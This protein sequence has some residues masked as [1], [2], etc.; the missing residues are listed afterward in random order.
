M[1]RRRHSHR[2]DDTRGFFRK[3]FC[4]SPIGQIFERDAWAKRLLQPRLEQGGH[5]AELERKHQNNV[6]SPS[7]LA[8]GVSMLIGNFSIFVLLLALGKRGV[9]PGEI[10]ARDLMAS[11]PRS[12]LVGVRQ[13][14]AEV[15]VPQCGCAFPVTIRLESAAFISWLPRSTRTLR[16]LLR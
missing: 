4:C 1:D 5:R 7:R 8:G 2:Y 6:I 9:E 16:R 15:S 11:T 12:M 14:V 3:Q 13:G 10:L